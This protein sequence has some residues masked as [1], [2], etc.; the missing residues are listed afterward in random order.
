MSKL[1]ILN[2]IFHPNQGSSIIK[3]IQKTFI[4]YELCFLY[5]HL[6][7]RHY[8]CSENSQPFKNKPIIGLRLYLKGLLSPTEYQPKN[9]CSF[10]WRLSSYSYHFWRRGKP[11]KLFFRN[12][13][14]Y[15][16][17]S[18]YGTP[19]HLFSDISV[20]LCTCQRAFFRYWIHW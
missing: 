20:R 16:S 17:A 1:I 18:S 12:S 6:I 10:I 19:F 2:I 9:S 15:Y 7:M 3:K 11:V 14:S 4:S 8:W 13:N 5:L